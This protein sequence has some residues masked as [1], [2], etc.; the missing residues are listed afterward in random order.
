MTTKADMLILDD[1]KLPQF[2]QRVLGEQL[3]WLIKL[4]W[5]AVVGIVVAGLV[6]TQVFPVLASAR[7][8][9]ICGGI[10]FVC[11]LFYLWV[12]TKRSSPTHLWDIVL[13]MVQVEV[14]LTVLT[15][16]LHFTG[17]ITNPFILF[18][19]FHVIIATIILPRTLS[20]SVGISAISMFGLMAIG[21]LSAWPWLKHHPLG[22][23]STGSLWRNPVYVL[24]TFVAF[25]ATVVLT[26]YLTRTIV[27][28][29]TAKELEAA[30]NKDVLEAV[31]T[32]MGEG[33]VFVTNDGKVTICN[34]AAEEWT[35]SSSS[36]NGSDQ[37]KPGSL[38]GF[39]P[40]LAE[41][42]KSLLA[43]DDKVVIACKPIKFN[44]DNQ[45]KSYIEGKTCPVVDVDGHRLGYVVVG[46]DVTEH[47]K[48]E[49]DL[50][51]RTLE[52]AEINEMLKMSRIEMAQREKMVAIGQM[53]SGIA[54]EIGNPLAS[55]SS[56]VQYLQRKL[57][58]PE[59]N[60]QLS[61]IRK[62]V[63]R[64]SVILKRMLSLSR[65]ATS[66]YKWTDINKTID[67]TLSLIRF[68][69]RAKAVAIKSIPN[70]EL[71]MV[72]LNPQHLEQVLLNVV[73]NALD[74]MI[75][76][77]PEQQHTLEVVREFKDE[78]VEI[79]VSDTGIGMSAD[80]CRRAFESFFTT[81]EIGKGTGLSLYISYNLVTEI[82][83]TINLDSEPG[84]GTTVTIRVPIGPKKHLISA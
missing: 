4:R 27:A 25:V 18:Y 45:Q 44:L 78:I 35:A 31:I 50:M 34:P 65:P 56:V 48:L 23:S 72:W 84:V 76:K 6:C 42:V 71:P 64:I 19:V 68:D 61:L 29:I 8:I 20:F 59:Q 11:N 7:P 14:D 12:V 16:L 38:E 82:D 24:G 39:L 15:I 79:R 66:E 13:G 53:A 22:F 9:Y 3:G 62:Q 77:G 32:A 52:T 57:T 30:R 2:M 73:T 46:Q 83:G 74:A 36:G 55:L 47:K 43:I 49:H 75:A 63:D 1:E 70:R 69:K 60:E 21:E 41:H 40:G 80:V 17:G 26:Q 33:L 28:R 81:K 51:E 54:H 37:R 67:G 5:L 10:L 58:T